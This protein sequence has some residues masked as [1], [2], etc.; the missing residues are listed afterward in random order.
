MNVSKARYIRLVT[1]SKNLTLQ[2]LKNE[3]RRHPLAKEVAMDYDTEVFDA[4]LD[5][6]NIDSFYRLWVEMSFAA[7][8]KPTLGIVNNHVAL[9]ILSCNR[10]SVLKSPKSGGFPLNVYYSAEVAQ[11]FN[12]SVNRIHMF[13]SLASKDRVAS[14][15]RWIYADNRLNRYLLS[16]IFNS[17][18]LLDRL[19]LS[20]M[21]LLLI[22]YLL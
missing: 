18:S 7:P 12:P 17:L 3:L 22:I 16:D 11:V 4:W 20:T 8:H 2:Q 10:D 14:G 19:V 21:I 6:R 13:E 1:K 15:F 9:S 5:N